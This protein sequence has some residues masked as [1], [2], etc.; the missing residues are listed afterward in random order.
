MEENDEKFQMKYDY[1]TIINMNLSQWQNLFSEFNEKHGDENSV[2]S[3]NNTIQFI[4]SD[5]YKLS[6]NIQENLP[7]FDISNKLGSPDDYQN[8]KRE[9]KILSGPFLELS[10]GDLII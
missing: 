3:K 5:K 8:S 4:D 7:K 9:E 6:I 1:K 2:I 10:N